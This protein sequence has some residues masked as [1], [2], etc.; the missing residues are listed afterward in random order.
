M[1]YKLPRGLACDPCHALREKEG[2]EQRAGQVA[3]A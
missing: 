1:Y 3:C 2:E